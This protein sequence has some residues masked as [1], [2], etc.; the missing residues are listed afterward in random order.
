MKTII[1]VRHAKSSWKNPDLHDHD[2]PLNKRGKGDVV[3]MGEKLKERRTMPDLILSS[4]AKRARKTAKSIANAIGF[5]KG[6]ILFNEYLYHAT[7]AALF[8]LVRKQGDRE[9]RIMLCGHNNTFTDFANLLLEGKSIDNIPTTGV[10]AIGFHIDRWKK[11]E[12]GKGE[13]LFFDYPKRYREIGS[14][15]TP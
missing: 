12:T 3:L 4:S 8:A 1:L 5:P 11:V 2:R 7:A 15:P 13:L 6:G 9:E 14:F 10:C